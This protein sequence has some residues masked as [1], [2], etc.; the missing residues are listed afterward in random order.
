MAKY[1]VDV[2]FVSRA[3]RTLYEI[4]P[5]LLANRM[6]TGHTDVRVRYQNQNMPLPMCAE[7]GKHLPGSPEFCTLAAFRE[8][9]KEL[10]PTDWEGECSY[11][12][13][14][15]QKDREAALAM[16]VKTIPKP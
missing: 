10:T 8:R 9:V 12:P 5:S 1:H 11:V 13:G 2:W 3:V 15:K 16:A 4:P 14:N 7:Q 6:L